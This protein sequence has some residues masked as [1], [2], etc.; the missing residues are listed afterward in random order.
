MG[1][2]IDGFRVVDEFNVHNCFPFLIKFMNVP[3][4]KRMKKDFQMVPMVVPGPKEPGDLTTWLRPLKRE[5]RRLE[6]GVHAFDGHAQEPFL[7]RAYIVC[8]LG[9]QKAINTLLQMKGANSEFG[10][11][12]CWN[13]GEEYDGIYYYP[14]RPEEP[15][16]MRTG[17][18]QTMRELHASGRGRS[19][20]QREV[21]IRGLTPLIDVESIQ[22]PRG[23]P[24]GPMH[25]LEIGIFEKLL[26]KLWRGTHGFDGGRRGR[27]RSQSHDDGA[28]ARSLDSARNNTQDSQQR[29]QSRRRGRRRGQS[30]DSGGGSQQPNIQP[31]DYILS[32]D[33][34]KDIG[35]ELVA[36]TKTVPASIARALRDITTH[37]S[38]YRA[39]SWSTFILLYAIPVLKDRLPNKYL[40]NL[41]VFIRAY[42][43][44]LR[45]EHTPE[46]IEE[47]RALWIE[48]VEGYQDIYVRY[49][50]ADADSEPLPLDPERIRLM[51]TNVHATL[52]IADHIL[53]LGNT[54]VYWEYSVERL[55]DMLQGMIRSRVK[56][57]E[58]LINA[59]GVHELIKVAAHARPNLGLNNP[60]KNRQPP[61]AYPTDTGF[62]LRKQY[63]VDIKTP[64]YQELQT[65]LNQYIHKIALAGHHQV[66]PNAETY[67][68]WKMGTTNNIS[69]SR[70]SQRKTDK[71]R[72]SQYIRY[73]KSGGLWG[74]AEVLYFVKATVPGLARRGAVSP[75][76]TPENSDSES[77]D[78]NNST[79]GAEVFDDGRCKGTSGNPPRWS[80][81]GRIYEHYVALIQPWITTT[82]E[83]GVLFERERAN[84]LIIDLRTISSLVGRFET[85][86]G[87]WIVSRSEFSIVETVQDQF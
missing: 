37:V 66:E 53:D 83:Y 30:Q 14:Y 55:G 70:R 16:V 5:L 74:Y 19:R 57:S 50:A 17:M 87:D 35:R 29:S 47:M 33:Q 65:V 34:W 36:A 56:I 1:Y 82:S 18:R 21:G 32:N 52:H 3:Q 8:T 86:S 60:Q 54:R 44:M 20:R 15:L 27:S 40:K 25:V 4:N 69:G 28:R 76:S 63:E 73:G 64:E 7:M 49:Q 67:E 85:V 78:D 12:Q 75:P 80:H 9:D 81:V 61:G 84:P 11:R 22:I 39:S 58:G 26:F 43:M 24:Y 51:T 42:E 72:A 23:L 68:R 77:D 6:K 13:K 62:L 79:T 31:P 59:V 41:Q 48:F 45:T 2:G 38:G 71:N 10:C 46:S